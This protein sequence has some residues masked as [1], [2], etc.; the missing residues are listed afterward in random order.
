MGLGLLS[1]RYG[2]WEFTEAICCLFER[3]YKVVEHEP[4]PVIHMEKPVSI[5]WVGPQDGW[6]GASWDL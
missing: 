2:C 5:A 3:I 6:D 1:K 4:R